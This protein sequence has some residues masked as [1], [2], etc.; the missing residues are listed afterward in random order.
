MLVEIITE[1]AKPSD[2]MAKLLN[3]AEVQ[4]IITEKETMRSLLE[5]D[6]LKVTETGAFGMP[7]F[8]VKNRTGEVETF[9]GSDR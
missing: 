1:A 6:T 2:T 7:W 3:R 9:F 4:R 8:E 5:K